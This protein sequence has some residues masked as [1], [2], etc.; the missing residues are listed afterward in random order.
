[1]RSFFGFLGFVA[2]LV[3]LL[4]AFAVPAVVSPMV[5]SAV[6]AASP[7]GDHQLDVQVKVDALGLIRGF[8]SEIRVS[9]TNLERDGSTIE[10]LDV[11]VHT[12]GIGDHAFQETS[13]GLDGVSILD[14]D[15]ALIGVDRI[16]LSGPSTGVTATATM[17]RAAA[18]AFIEHAFAT[19]GVAVSGVELASDGLVIVV[20]DQR[21]EVPVGVEDGALVIPDLLGAG[22]LAL[23]SPQPDDQWRLSSAT[24][25]PN[26]LVIVA[27]VNA[28]AL[29]GD[30]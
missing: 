27:S 10:S 19:Q 16:A 9:G 20:F 8:V 2:V 30:P 18:L 12:V 21:V 29:L 22:P 4:A 6:R 17:D 23:L 25:S 1:M 3:V 15:G 26:G 24:I 7:F 28:E 5:A 11:T 14:V 13:G